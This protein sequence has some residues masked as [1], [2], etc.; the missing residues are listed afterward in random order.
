MKK[1]MLLFYIRGMLAFSGTAIAGEKDEPVT[2]FW[3]TK[4]TSAFRVYRFYDMSYHVLCYA[5]QNSM[6]CIP[7]KHLDSNTQKGIGKMIKE[8]RQLKVLQD[9]IKLGP[10]DYSTT[11]K[12]GKT[13]E[14]KGDL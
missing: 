2:R 14:K 11:S 1:V 13:K 4:S 12:E 6:D 3:S 10:I 8:N 7:W 5:N 9:I